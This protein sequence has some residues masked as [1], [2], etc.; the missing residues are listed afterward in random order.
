MYANANIAAAM[1][2]NQAVLQSNHE[3]SMIMI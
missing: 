2:T 3:P 1:K